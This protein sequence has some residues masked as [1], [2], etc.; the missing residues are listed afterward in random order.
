VYGDR[1]A[2]RLV[3]TQR[4]GDRALSFGHTPVRKRRLCIGF[5]IRQ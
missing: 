1:G 3:L 5:V 2:G 4:R